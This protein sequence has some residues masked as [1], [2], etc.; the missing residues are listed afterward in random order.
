[1]SRGKKFVAL[2]LMT[3]IV[4]VVLGAIWGHKG[5]DPTGTPLQIE[6]D[7]AIVGVIEDGPELAPQFAARTAANRCRRHAFA[8]LPLAIHTLCR[9]LRTYPPIER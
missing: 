4:I 1:M 9:H 5:G 7:D 8:A 6:D 3:F 2:S